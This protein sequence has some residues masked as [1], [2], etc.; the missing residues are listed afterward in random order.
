MK[1]TKKKIAAM[2]MAS[3]M[4]LSFAMPVCAADLTG[5]HTEATD[6]TQQAGADNSSNADSGLIVDD[7]GSKGDNSLLDSD[8]LNEVKAK[9]GSISVK[10]TD[11]KSGTSKENVEM[12][13]LKVATIK[14]GEY[15]LDE[16]YKSLNID[17]NSIQNATDLEKAATALSEK[18]GNGTLLKSD[19]NGMASFDDLEV[20]V[21]LV[22]ATKTSSYDDVTP[23]LIAIPTWDESKGEMAYDVNVTPK[24]TPKPDSTKT[25][26]TAPQTNVNS[27]VALYLGGAAVVAAALVGVNVS[28][29]KKSKSESK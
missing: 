8:K 28:K 20:G 7:E 27:P 12:S 23:S 18:S 16:A 13:C 5:Q 4:I 29:K 25:T 19:A 3:T 22:K 10:L 17:L 11:G 1:K 24:H 15:V 21:Y 9:T 26:K 6:N 2:A 14:G